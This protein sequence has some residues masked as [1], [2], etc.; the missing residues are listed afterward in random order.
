MT[1]AALKIPAYCP[2]RRIEPDH[3][4]RPVDH[5]PD[6]RQ[7]LPRINLG[8]GQGGCTW[9]RTMGAIRWGSSN[10]LL[11]QAALSSERPTSSET[12][13]PKIGF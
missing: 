13:A 12:Q 9:R 10:F 4:H 2:D 3:Q 8:G 7:Q 6:S 1:V 11:K 5:H